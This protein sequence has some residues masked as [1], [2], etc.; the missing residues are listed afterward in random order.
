LISR[1]S[2]KIYSNKIRS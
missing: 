2:N 1:F